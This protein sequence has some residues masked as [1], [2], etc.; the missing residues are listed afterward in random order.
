[1]YN[2]NKTQLKGANHVLAE[3]MAKR[4]EMAA[5]KLDDAVE[6][7]GRLKMRLEEEEKSRVVAI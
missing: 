5:E 3:A 4:S 7:I 1:M 2:V 6:E